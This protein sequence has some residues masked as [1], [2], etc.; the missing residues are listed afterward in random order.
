MARGSTWTAAAV[1]RVLRRLP[2]RH[3][4]ASARRACRETEVAAVRIYSNAPGKLA[5][6]MWPQNVRKR[7][8]AVTALVLAVTTLLATL[9][10]RRAASHRSESMFKLSSSDARNCE[11]R[12]S[13]KAA[14]LNRPHFFAILMALST[15]NAE[16]VHAA[17]VWLECKGSLVVDGVDG[18][19]GPHDDIYVWDSELSRIFYYDVRSKTLSALGTGRTDELRLSDEQIFAH[20]SITSPN[21]GGTMV[22]DWSLDRRTLKLVHT[23]TATGPTGGKTIIWRWREQ[24][25]VTSPRE[26]QKPKT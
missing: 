2:A 15:L 7:L 22:A 23:A 18:I 21:S 9:L 4:S 11:R 25:A 19:N 20:Y 1:Q 12:V 5:H 26:T 17:P 10:A 13:W 16:A 8:T 6:M 24:C 14:H 3:K